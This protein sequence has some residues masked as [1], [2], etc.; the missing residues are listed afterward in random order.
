MTHSPPAS[1]EMRTAGKSRKQDRPSR[2]R[3][4]GGICRDIPANTAPHP[5][6]RVRQPLPKGALQDELHLGC[7]LDDQGHANRVEADR[8]GAP[9]LA[10]GPWLNTLDSGD[11]ADDVVRHLDFVEHRPELEV[12]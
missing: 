12:R 3:M 1:E 10:P 4:R 5:F 8:T 6:T 11:Q 9:A 2:K 7:L